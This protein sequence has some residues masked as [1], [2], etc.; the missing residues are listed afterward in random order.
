MALAY[1]IKHMFS[2]AHICEGDGTPHGNLGNTM[3]K[4]LLSLI[5]ML[6][7]FAAVAMSIKALQTRTVA[8]DQAQTGAR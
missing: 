2:M 6:A 5:L 3:K 1:P 7:V 4:T 8:P